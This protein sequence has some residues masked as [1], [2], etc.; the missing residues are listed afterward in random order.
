MIRHDKYALHQ[1]L[2]IF[3]SLEEISNWME[4]ELKESVRIRRLEWY[5]IG[6]EGFTGLGTESDM[7]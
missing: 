1:T 6:R 4:T 3:K 5:W 7:S 2:L